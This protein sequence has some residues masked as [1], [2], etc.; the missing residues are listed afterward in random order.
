MFFPVSQKQL[1]ELIGATVAV[2]FSLTTAQSLSI[3]NLRRHLL[4]V[5][6]F[7]GLRCQMHLSLLLAEHGWMLLD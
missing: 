2:S 4:F 6:L 7:A 5:C 3:H 1:A